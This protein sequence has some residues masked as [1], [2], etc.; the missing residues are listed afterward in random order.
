MSYHETYEFFAIDRCLSPPE[1]RALRAISTRATITPARFHNFYNWS[2]LKGDPFGML[3]RYFDLFVHT[4][5][6][7]PDWGMLRFPADSV[8]LPRWRPY[9]TVQRGA[10]RSARVASVMA[11]RD[12]L[13]LDMA[14]AEDAMLHETRSGHRESPDDEWYD[15]EWYGNE[16]YDDE[17]YEMSMDEASW[18]VPL[19]LVRADLLVGDL[20][21]LYLLWLLSVQCGERRAAAIEPP[22]PPGGAPMTGSLY[23]FSEFLRLNPDLLAAALDAPP[24]EPRT[25]GQLLEAARAHEAERERAEVARAA[26]ERS[27]RLASLA[28]RQEAEWSEIDELLGAPKVLPS[29]YS[30]VIKRLTDLRELG[31]DRGEEAVFQERLRA[32]LE[33]RGSKATLLRHVREAHL[34][35]GG[36]GG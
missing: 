8:D 15:D 30:D 35:G 34:T 4:G 12:M 10:R 32:L 21:P 24:A 18:P 33:R 9:V 1:M 17:I 27:K 28:R 3:G 31:V 36:E 13:I 11:V 22:R 5:N 14:P 23:L 29:V 25:A 6:G 2:G 7:R 20:R 19:A 16:R 26:A